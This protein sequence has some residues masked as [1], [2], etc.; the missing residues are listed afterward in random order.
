LERFRGA[1]TPIGAAP[2]QSL[3]MAAD[4]SMPQVTRDSAA[5][6]SHLWTIEITIRDKPRG[7]AAIF[8]SAA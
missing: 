1:D 7:G 4:R 3:C 5:G 8:G 6:A 2:E